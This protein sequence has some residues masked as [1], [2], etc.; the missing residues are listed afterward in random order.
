MIQTEKYVSL[1]S[2]SILEALT[3]HGK[4][5]VQFTGLSIQFIFYGFAL[6]AHPFKVQANW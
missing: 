3:R 2:L 4:P 6:V 1:H 5:I